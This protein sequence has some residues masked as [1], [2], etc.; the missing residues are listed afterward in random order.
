MNGSKLLEK[1]K[2]EALLFTKKK[3]KNS[4]HRGTAVNLFICLLVLCSMVH[5]NVVCT[6][7]TH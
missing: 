6:L 5:S 4:K 1:K 7:L 3:K 2:E